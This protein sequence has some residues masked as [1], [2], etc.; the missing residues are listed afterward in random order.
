MNTIEKVRRLGSAIFA[1]VNAWF[2]VE[3]KGE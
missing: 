1:V 3:R 2:G